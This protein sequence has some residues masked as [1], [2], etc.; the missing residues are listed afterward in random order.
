MPL[1]SWSLFE[2]YT[3]TCTCTDAAMAPAEQPPKITSVAL[4]IPLRLR[5]LCVAM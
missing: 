1:S 4:S 3:H 5:V 2:L